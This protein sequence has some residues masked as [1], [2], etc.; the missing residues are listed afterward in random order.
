MALHFMI[1][2]VSLLCYA[3]TPQTPVRFVPVCRQHLLTIPK[4]SVEEQSTIKYVSNKPINIEQTDC[5]LSELKWAA[6][7]SFIKAA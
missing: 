6:R 4:S 5:S 2:L 7:C 3:A 1:F